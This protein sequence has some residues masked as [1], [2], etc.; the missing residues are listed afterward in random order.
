MPEG[1]PE[2]P[3]LSYRA[4]I[5]GRWRGRWTPA[6]AFL[7]VGGCFAAVNGL[8]FVAGVATDPETPLLSRT[9]ALV[10]LPAIPFAFGC[11]SLFPPPMAGPG[12]T[13]WDYGVLAGTMLLG[14]CAWGTLAA[15]AAWLMRLGEP[16]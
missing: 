3:Q 1:E 11:V 5:A 16:K 10:N 9:V 2:L 13:A 14:S 15:A 12:F 4:P 6:V 8:L 7:W